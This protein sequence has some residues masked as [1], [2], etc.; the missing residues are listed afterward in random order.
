MLCAGAAAQAAVHDV[1]KPCGA[2]PGA[3]GDGIT[4]DTARI[5]CH[6]D[7]A[8]AAKGGAVYIPRGT[9][10]VTSPILVGGDSVTLYGDG[11]GSLLRSETGDHTVF[12]VQGRRH[13]IFR[14]L[15]IAERDRDDAG[16]LLPFPSL[17]GVGIHV[18]GSSLDVMLENVRTRGFG[19]GIAF[20]AGDNATIYDVTLRDVWCETASGYG[21]Q[22]FGVQKLRAYDLRAWRNTSTGVK[23]GQGTQDWEIHGGRVWSN[24]LHGIS[25]YSG[26]EKWLI[27]GTQ[28]DR[29]IGSG[30]LVK[31]GDVTTENDPSTEGSIVG[32]VA[33]LN[34]QSGLDFWVGSPAAVPLPHHVAVSGGSF[35]R[36]AQSG[37]RVGDGRNLSISGSVVKENGQYGIFVRQTSFD[38]S[39][40]GVLVAGNGQ[41][42]AA[43]P[44]HGHSGIY[45]GGQGVRVIGAQVN[46][47]NDDDAIGDPAGASSHKHSI[48]IASTASD[49]LVEGCVL[50][51]AV[52]A[53]IGGSLGAAVLRDNTGFATQSS[54]LATLTGATTR[55]VVPHGLARAPLAQDVTVT[56]AASWGAA[57][58][59]WIESVGPASFAI[60]MD[61]APGADVGFA[62]RADATGH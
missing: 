1:T 62:W 47:I 17:T 40:L 59:F 23:I 15:Y 60:A 37:I 52:Q 53:E 28:I 58:R 26:G 6:V 27:A 9:Y 55:V 30:L 11:M 10:K 36:N 49:V 54:G 39:L 5:R 4:D 57:S 8:A 19:S 14:D 42:F 35:S 7:A 43:D 44:A 33:E 12:G 38:I 32:V 50:R 16:K 46:G 18:S 41:E 3:V 34:T 24:G 20:F 13:V 31:A 51:N 21:L 48:E 61:R 22:F 45:I 56:P 29:N 25:T 2:N